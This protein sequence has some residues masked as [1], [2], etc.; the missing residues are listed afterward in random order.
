LDAF[1]AAGRFVTLTSQ[2]E[3]YADKAASEALQFNGATIAV[4]NSPCTNAPCMQ[5]SIQWPEGHSTARAEAAEASKRLNAQSKTDN[6]RRQQL[7]LPSAVHPALCSSAEALCFPPSWVESMK[8]MTA[9]C[10]SA[11]I[12][13][14]LSCFH[15]FNPLH[16]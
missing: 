7:F 5:N 2:G 9:D 16:S 15:A 12:A 14:M 6:S 4:A 3:V 10:Q 11:V 8:A 1:Y 13:F